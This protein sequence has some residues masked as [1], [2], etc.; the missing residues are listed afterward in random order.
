MKYLIALALIVFSVAAAFAQNSNLNASRPVQPTFSA[1]TMDGKP[2]DLA[3]LRGKIVVINLWFVN[4]PNCVEEIKMLNDVVDKYKDNK[5]VVF[6]GL[7]ASKKPLLEQFLKKN[8]FKYQIVP[9]ATM[10]ILSKFGTPDKDGN[11]NVPFPMHYVLDREGRI[12]V[13]TQG[14]K[15]VESVK[16]ELASQTNT[17]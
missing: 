9:D 16:I 5:D 13:K 6:L 4:C 1:V 2:V 3:A 11:I 8:P 15:G 10:I 17:K 12:V 7:A 14:I